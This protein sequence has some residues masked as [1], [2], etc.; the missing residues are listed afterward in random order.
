MR[1]EVRD[2]DDLIDLGVIASIIWQSKIMIVVITGILAV[3]SVV[4]ALSLSDQY[5]ATVTVVPTESTG[6]SSLGRLAG[7]FGGLASF[8][9]INLASD[10]GAN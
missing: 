8:A 2:R 7:Q 1:A 3:A 5:R 4:Y 10:S 6:I 9:G